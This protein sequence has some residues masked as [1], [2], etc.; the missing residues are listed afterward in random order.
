MTRAGLDFEV[1]KRPH[2]I[3]G[4]GGSGDI[5]TQSALSCAIIRTDTGEEIGDVSKTY[6]IAQ[7]QEIAAP[8]VQ[9][10]YDGY[11]NFQKGGIINRG[12]KF[13]LEFETKQDNIHGEDLRRRIIVGGSHDGSW[14]LFFKT[15]VWRQVCSNGMMG[16]GLQDT[17]R[18][19]HTT[20]WKESYNGVLRQLQ[21]TDVFYNRALEKYNAMFNVRIDLPR[22]RELTRKLL[23]IDDKEAASSRKQNQLVDIISLTHRGRGIIGNNQ[24]QGT[25]AAWYNAVVEYVDHHSI[26]S[27]GSQRQ[28]LNEKRFMSAFFGSGEDRK[29][30]AFELAESLI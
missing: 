13:Y 12:Q 15:Y 18:V 27:T 6:A 26:Q 24:I 5:Y 19:R 30:K 17:F 9:A 16:F 14:A 25:V 29:K 4:F 7:Y 11:L 10:A 28:S 8:F 22:M 2:Y 1:E 23:E 3:R 20:N 21:Q